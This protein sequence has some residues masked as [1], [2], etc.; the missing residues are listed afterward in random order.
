MYSITIRILSCLLVSNLAL[1]SEEAATAAANQQRSSETAA[2][3]QVAPL[4]LDAEGPGALFSSIEAAAIDALTYS[5]LQARDACDPE[6]MRGGTIHPIGEDHYSYGEVHHADRWSAHRISYI[7]KPRD[8]ARFHLYPVNQDTDDNRINERA[9]RADLRSVSVVDPLHRP[10]YILHPSLAIRAYRGEDSH[11]VEAASLRA[12][13]PPRL[14]ARKCS[15]EELPLGR[16]S[17]SSRIAET[18]RSAPP[19]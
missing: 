4:Q 9:S 3:F 12:P 5:Y 6:F 15:S 2:T 10:L 11:T 1:A 18:N 7:F 19:H 17:G 14:F 16:L 8:V 13:A